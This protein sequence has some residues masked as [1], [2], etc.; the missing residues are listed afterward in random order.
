MNKVLGRYR[1]TYE[2]G[3]IQEKNLISHDVYTDM[4]KPLQSD[5]Y[6][7]ELLLSKKNVNKKSVKEQIQE[8]KKEISN[9]VL[10]NEWFTNKSPL[11]TAHLTGILSLP[12]NQGGDIKCKI[13]LVQ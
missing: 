13:E 10:S 7:L 1:I 4:I 2:C 11:Y 9:I 8:C 12:K 5:I 3:V 6:E